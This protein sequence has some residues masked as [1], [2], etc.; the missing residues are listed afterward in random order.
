MCVPS[1]LI[2]VD[3]LRPSLAGT[4]RTTW[5]DRHRCLQRAMGGLGRTDKGVLSQGNKRI[6]G[7]RQDQ[8]PA[9]SRG[10]FVCE[11]IF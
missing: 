10:G 9:G 6:K 4:E 1:V 2:T 3:I 5:P 8:G 7:Q 11:L